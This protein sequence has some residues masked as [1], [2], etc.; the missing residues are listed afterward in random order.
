MR[1]TKEVKFQRRNDVFESVLKISTNRYCKSTSRVLRVLVF[2]IIAK[3]FTFR[4]TLRTAQGHGTFPGEAMQVMRALNIS[5]TRVT[6]QGQLLPAALAL[7]SVP[8][9]V[10]QRVP[11]CKTVR[12]CFVRSRRLDD[13][14]ILV[15]SADG[16]QRWRRHRQ[17]VF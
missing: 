4:R 9:L 5:P 6:K 8:P 11:G 10:V 7:G 15:S 3:I 17:M 13:A 1:N 2:K 14:R 12:S 16:D